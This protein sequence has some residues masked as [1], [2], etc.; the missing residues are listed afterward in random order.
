MVRHNGGHSVAGREL[1]CGVVKTGV[2]YSRKKK[3]MEKRNGEKK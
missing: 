3:E 2:V 1:L